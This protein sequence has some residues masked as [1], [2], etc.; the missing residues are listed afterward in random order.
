MADFS[1]TAAFEAGI[2]AHRAG[3]W[4]EAERYY[5][6]IL[7][8]HPHHLET[9]VMLGQLLTETD[10]AEAALALFD[11]ALR[12]DPARGEVYGAQGAA[13]RR[14]GRPA[15]AVASYRRALALK[16]DALVARVNLGNALL[17]LGEGDEAAETFRAVIALAP[18]LPEAQFGLGRALH[19]TGQLEAAIEPL[20]QALA[21]RPDYAAAYDALGQVACDLGRWNEA[22]AFHAEALQRD[23][24][25]PGFY[26]HF[27]IALYN[28]GELQTAEGSFRLALS[29][30]PDDVLAHFNLAAV[31][32][33]AGRLAEGWAEYEWRRRLRGFPALQTTR[34][35]WRGEPLA[36]KTLLLYGEQGL[37]DTLHFARYAQLAAEQGARVVMAVQKPLLR[38]MRS[39]PGVAEVVALGGAVSAD[40]H[41]P[42]L[43]A[44]W[45]FGTTADTI[46]ARTPYLF[47]APEDAR[48]WGERLA[49]LTGL[50]VGLVWAGD[51]RPDD[52][53]AHLVDRRR[54]LTLAQLAPLAAIPG[55]TFVSLQKGA[56]A[57]QAKA[58]P[59]GLHLLDWMDEIEDFADTAAL[60]SQLDLVISVDTSVVHLV[61]AMGKPVWI[62]SRFDGCWRWQDRDDSP[63]YPTARL[64]RQTAPGDW[65]GPLAA[66]TAALRELS[67]ANKT[68]G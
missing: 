42:L 22:I 20:R 13:L 50:K 27:G 44:P 67:G 34:P 29:L 6:Q 25:G 28:C 65:T 15:E 35:E 54:S 66:L 26:T 2:S 57:V 23:P 39:V 11:T 48:R 36:G 4:A 68:G 49:N 38:L 61:G 5:R 63:W 62:L 7:L 46:P 32:L 52:R 30:N 47:P 31:L 37:G 41:L 60:V 58:P 51:P 33:R 9:L 40:Y 24:N 43:S 19:L 8:S 14:L 21:L 16:P 17:D 10:R 53:A 59:A 18:A 3:D 64:F 1:I 56:P 12:V 45:R 55:I